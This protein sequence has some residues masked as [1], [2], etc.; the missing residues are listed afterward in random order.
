MVPVPM[1]PVKSGLPAAEAREA[2]LHDSWKSLMSVHSLASEQSHQT[3][4]TVTAC[5]FC[6]RKKAKGQTTKVDAKLSN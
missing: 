2:Q 1:N 4:V 6:K 3:F 5:I